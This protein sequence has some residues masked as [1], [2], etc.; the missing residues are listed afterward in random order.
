MPRTARVKSSTGIYHI[1][2]RGINRETIFRDDEDSNKFLQTLSKYR[3]KCGFQL[4]AYCLMNNHIHLLIKEEAEDLSISLKRIG[5]SYVYWYNWKHERCGPLFQDRFRSEA[6]EDDQYFLTVL[7]Y[8]HQNP[9][10]ANIVGKL[11][12]YHWSSYPEYLK[13]SSLIDKDFPLRLFAVNEVNAISKFVEFHQLKKSESCLEVSEKRKW[14]DKDAAVLITD[15]C[16]VDDCKDLGKMDIS[17]Q[18]T[19]YKQLYDKGLSV[20]QLSRL[21][22]VGRWM[23]YQA[24]KEDK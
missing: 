8:I 6:V 22:G 5:T 17:K 3:A 11:S 24:I 13:E 20:L 16:G 12:E 18:N 1:I 21:T 19:C 10:K 7:R 4:Y 14:K 23:I 9:L 2:L 15:L